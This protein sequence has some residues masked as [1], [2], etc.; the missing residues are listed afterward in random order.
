MWQS[1]LRSG[2]SFPHREIVNEVGNEDIDLIQAIEESRSLAESTNVSPHLSSQ[3][4]VHAHLEPRTESVAF[5]TPSAVVCFELDDSD[6]MSILTMQHGTGLFTGDPNGP[7]IL[8]LRQN[9]N[10]LKSELKLK[11]T[12]VLNDNDMFNFLMKYLAGGARDQA[13]D[14][15]RR[16]RNEL[17]ARNAAKSEQYIRD[18]AAY[19]K[20]K[21]DYDALPADEKAAA[22]EPQA[23]AVHVDDEVYDKP[24]EQFWTMMEK[25]YPEKSTTRMEEFRD[26]AMRSNE[27]VASLVQRMQT[28]MHA[29]DRPEEMAVFKLIAAI[30]PTE[31][32]KEVHRQLLTTSL[33]TS[34]WT[35]ELVGQ[36]AIKIDQATTQANLWSATMHAAAPPRPMVRA[37]TVLAAPSSHGPSRKQ[38]TLQCHKCL[39]YGHIARDCRSSAVV[40]GGSAR[41]QPKTAADSEPIC[42]HCGEPG[43]YANKCARKRAELA[44][45][46]ASKKWC[47]FHKTDSHDTAECKALQAGKTPRA[48]SA[49]ARAAA[50]AAAAYDIS[51]ESQP[52][53]AQL[54]A[55]WD[56]HHNNP[57]GY[58]ARI[59]STLVSKRCAHVPAGNVAP[60]HTGLTRRT[61]TK[62]E[63]LRGPLS[64]MPLSFLPKDFL[65]APVRPP[66]GMLTMP[67]NVEPVLE[68][69]PTT[70][71]PLEPIHTT[72]APALAAGPEPVQI[73]AVPA[74][75]DAPTSLQPA[76]T[77]LDVPAAFEELPEDAPQRQG[78]IYAPSVPQIADNRN[79][80]HNV[81]F[82]RGKPLRGLKAFEDLYDPD[83]PNLGA[84]LSHLPGTYHSDR[85]AGFHRSPRI[86]NKGSN[87]A[88]LINGR[89]VHNLLLDSG[90]EAVITGRSGAAAMGITPDMIDRNAIVIRTCT[91]ALTERLDQTKEPVSFVLNPDTPD[92]LTIMAHVVIVNQNVPDTLIGMSVMGPAELTPDM[93]KKRAKYYVEKGQTARKCFLRCH[94]PIDYSKPPLRGYQALNAYTC[95]VLP[96]IKSPSNAQAIAD[97]RCKLGNFQRRALPEMTEIF[98]RSIRS[99]ATPDR[100]PPVIRDPEYRHLRPL[101][102]VLVDKKEALATPGPGMVVVELFS[103][104][105]ATTEALLR[106]GVTIRKVYACELDDK[107]R[108]IATRRLA[109]LHALFPQLLSV[110]AIKDCH[111]PLGNDVRKITRGQVS[112]LERPDLV[113]AGFPCQGFSRAADFALGLRD[114]RTGLLLEAVRIVHLINGIWPGQVGYLFENVDASDHP[115]PEVREEFNNVVKGLLGHGFAFDAVAVGSY[116]HRQRRWWTNLAPSTLMLEMLEKKFKHRNPDQTVQKILEPGHR[117][118]NASHARAPGRHSV[119]VRGE[120]LR[121]LSTFVTVRGSYAYQPGQQSM[122]QQANGFWDEPTAL[123]R[124]RAMGFM[125]GTTKVCPSISEADRRRILGSTMDMHSLQFLIGSIQ[126]FQFA[127]FTD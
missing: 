61:V 79:S 111:E 108:K 91:G 92:E 34:N 58:S 39:K 97:A 54:Q 37:P 102:T 126:C 125:D 64:L 93:R 1:R 82:K 55:L 11:P 66:P 95:A 57:N 116:A 114:S 46:G 127:F 23:P 33:E 53:L 56:A 65:D 35:V 29:L 122:I 26:F 28:L 19:D 3:S 2:P 86:D 120:P 36:I 43:H 68:A 45:S 7:S 49:S 15:E 110:E 98:D 104:L 17:R 89:V 124:E 63:R 118:Q 112:A 5:R 117:A 18:R 4:T 84:L 77:S 67:T 70:A 59:D 47:T 51:D 50:P 8:H 109:V 103:G 87:P 6:S 32:G 69:A 123:E 106:Q 88:M 48:Q 30:R 62:D 20:A 96:M 74:Q 99:L 107:T 85:S 81:P 100:P 90:A 113:V 78:M 40:K 13:A 76:N 72:P 71:A 14:L 80:E 83:N 119:N 31:L 27:T 105:M 38:Q 9:Y 73:E 22:T 10:T 24:V 44:K 115:Q 42:Y 12:V 16:M 75:T 41:T 60:V 52:S 21:A 101:A 121:A 94:F 25:L